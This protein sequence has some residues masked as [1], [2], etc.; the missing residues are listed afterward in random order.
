MGWRF[1]C[2]R[3]GLVL[4]GLKHQLEI[5]FRQKN[6]NK[7]ASLNVCI[8]LRLAGCFGGVNIRE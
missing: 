4:V 7:V 1:V 8:Y 3:K 6:A 5:V 2:I